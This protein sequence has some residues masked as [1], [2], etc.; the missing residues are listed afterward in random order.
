MKS[1]VVR[2]KRLRATLVDHCGLPNAGAGSTL[3]TGGFVTV[4]Y[5]PVWKDAE[6]L[7]QANADGKNCVADRTP[8]ELKWYTVTAVFCDV[9]PELHNMFTNNPIVT[10]YANKPV[11]FRVNKDVVTE[12]GVGLELWTGT[13][14]S[15]CEE[16][17]DDSYLTDEA[18]SAQGYGYWLTPGIKEATLGDVEIG[19]SVATFTLSGITF[20]A[21]AWGKG[22]YL[23]TATDANNTPGRLKTPIKKDEHLHYERVTIAP[24]EVTEGAVPLVLPTPYFAAVTP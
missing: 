12:T 2:G 1:Q 20:S 14:S 11:G 10:D 3:V 21:P 6:D 13:G 15:D 9:D 22:P 17:L 5:A 8:P 16:P 19:A 4:T 23:V 24:P 18:A 7:E